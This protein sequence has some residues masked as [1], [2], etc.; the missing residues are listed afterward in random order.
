VNAF[1]Y[2]VLFRGLQLHFVAEKVS[3]VVVLLR[4][5]LFVSGMENYCLIRVLPVK[6]FCQRISKI[7]EWIKITKLYTITLNR[8]FVSTN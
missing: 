6:R 1:S 2:V 3:E 4:I 5:G 8:P 7:L